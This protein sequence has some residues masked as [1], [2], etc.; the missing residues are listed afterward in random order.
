[1]VRAGRDPRTRLAGL[2]T[3]AAEHPFG[4]GGGGACPA[5]ARARFHAWLQWLADEQ[6]AAAQEAARAAGMRIG[7]IGDLAV[8][9]HP[10]GAD[11]WA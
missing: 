3:A 2:A 4:R 6:L 9:A 7:I 1:M 5:A 8:G 11:A 10:G